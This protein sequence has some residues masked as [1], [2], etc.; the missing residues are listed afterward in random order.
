MLIDFINYPFRTDTLT[1]IPYNG[2]SAVLTHGHARQLP[3]DPTIIGYQL[4][5]WEVAR[6]PHDHRTPANLCLICIACYLKF[7]H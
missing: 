4:I 2:I 3:G 6:G 5:R 1:R 7:K